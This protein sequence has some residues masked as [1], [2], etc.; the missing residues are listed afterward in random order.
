MKNRVIQGYSPD[1]M[2]L[3]F[4]EISAIPRPSGHEEQ[5][6]DYLVAFAE[7]YGLAYIRDTH[8]N[9]II[10]RPCAP[11]KEN[12]PTLMLQ[13]HSDMVC[14]LAPG[15]T[16]DFKREGLHLY[17]DEN[18]WIR[19]KNTS[20]GADDA[21]GMMMLLQ[22]LID[23][24]L[25][26]P[27][28]ECVFTAEEETGLIG[29]RM[30][31][32]TPLQARYMI[33][34]DSGP[35]GHA[36]IGCAGGGLVRLTKQFHTVSFEGSVLEIKISGLKS[37]HSGTCIHLG[38]A[39]A[40]QVMARI[41]DILI[42]QYNYHIS[43][44]E[45]GTQDNAIPFQARAELI[46]ENKEQSLAAQNLIE[47]LHTQL[48]KEFADDDPELHIQTKLQQDTTA[49]LSI[50]NTKSFVRLLRLLPNGVTQN[51][52]AFGGY[53]L[54]SLNFA[55]V[56]L[57]NG[58]AEFRF[59]L[60]SAR[61]SQYNMIFRT[62]KLLA[63]SESFTVIQED[64]YPG[65]PSQKKSPLCNLAKQGFLKLFGQELIARPFSAGLECGIFLEKMPWLDIIS[66]G[67]D[68]DG[69]HS[70]EEKMDPASASRLWRLVA[71]L[72][73]NIKDDHL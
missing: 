40:N 66:L 63:E 53:V 19:A 51:S 35:E 73:N 36:I 60:R 22:A 8:R 56:R 5:I 31:D 42:Q 58:S 6:G 59:Y 16:H 15:A 25:N 50:D 44:L 13:A 9:V 28:L 14:A 68:V 39:N 21:L 57:I 71:Y 3:F 62:L 38:R 24:T 49:A 10:K 64:T 29:A 52:T 46:F 26:N 34:L 33:N 72:I 67:S 20:L 65:W 12:A 41:L 1:S 30:L 17:L 23:P 37:G 54:S 32:T 27:P 48:K 2:F 18:N 55:V 45:G 69:C 47:Q 70:A 11:G 61:N 4:E 43:Y 7:K